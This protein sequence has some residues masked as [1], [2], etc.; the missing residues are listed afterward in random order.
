MTIF[1]PKIS[2]FY[3]AIHVFQIK[4][5][6]T[7]HNILHVDSQLCVLS[8]FM[9]ARL[10]LSPHYA[11]LARWMPLNTWSLLQLLQWRKQ[12]YSINQF[13]FWIVRL[14]A[15]DDDNKLSKDLSCDLHLRSIHVLD[16]NRGLDVDAKARATFTS[17]L[18]KF[19]CSLQWLNFRHQDKETCNPI[20]GVRRDSSHM[21]PLRSV[22]RGWLWLAISLNSSDLR[23]F[24]KDQQV[25]K[26]S[27]E[28]I[29]K[30]L[31]IKDLHYSNY[32]IL[33]GASCST[34]Q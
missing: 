19:F 14:A 23:N 28:V 6:K 15:S 1:E 9:A 17:R 3:W 21:P 31:H 5:H 20:Q 29:L 11:A 32:L 22:L 8:V 26:N 30:H 7:T 18:C 27:C 4:N 33:V 2:Q 12:V 25:C 24:N 34:W 16:F 10:R 13:S